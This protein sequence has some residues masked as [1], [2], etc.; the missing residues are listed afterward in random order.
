MFN[1]FSNKQDYSL[2]KH[3][4]SDGNPS[5]PKPWRSVNFYTPFHLLFTHRQAPGLTG[6]GPTKQQ[7]HDPFS[8]HLDWLYTAALKL[9]DYTNNQLSDLAIT[10]V[11]LWP[12]E[13]SYRTNVI[14]Y[15]NAKQRTWE[16]WNC[17][18]R[19]QGWYTERVWSVL[20]VEMIRGCGIWW[21]Y[22]LL[23][24]MYAC[25]QLNENCYLKAAI[26]VFLKNTEITKITFNIFADN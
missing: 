5:H 26:T 14:Y 20:F 1:Y 19:P 23:K 13:S 21:V 25:M 4:I 8:S 9:P 10:I 15:K 2:L 12:G 6:V 24:W 3:L 22:Q 7:T 17:I 11:Y 16:K 18:V